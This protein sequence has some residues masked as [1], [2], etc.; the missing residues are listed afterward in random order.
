MDE[1]AIRAEYKGRAQRYERLKQEV[2]YILE[3]R[4][5]AQ[6]IPL[7][8]TE[9]RIKTLDSLL[10]K[11]RRRD[12]Q[13]PFG[14]LHD[15]CGVRVVCLFR[16][17][18]DRIGEIVGDEF[19][20]EGEDDKRLTTPEEEFGYLSVH[21]VAT[22]PTH[23][24]G[25]RYEGL[26]GLRFEVQVRTIAMHAWA[27]VSHYLDYKSTHAVPTHLRRDFYALSGLFYTADSQFESFFRASGDAR[28]ATERKAQSP[29]G[30]ANEEI[31]LD[32]L[33][34]YLR[35]RFPDREHSDTAWISLLVDELTAAGYATIAELD[36][37]LA[38]S[39]AA[40]AEYEKDN[41]PK[42]APRYAA[43][44]VVRASLSIVSEEFLDARK[45]R[46]KDSLL[47]GRSLYAKYRRFAE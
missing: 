29:P 17:D 47:L 9:G 10:A 13:D 8:M 42:N 36:A 25:P 44:G 32:T 45:D 28:A 35:D 18:L 40:F 30:L 1:E 19:T 2:L 5:K 15:I 46:R 3:D 16:S 34:I 7:H 11:A 23:L 43:V 31:N 41:P 38:R 21:Y 4:L 20:V 26:N 22:L 33:A 37:D 14:D 27:T 24:S 12:T 39:V 6:D